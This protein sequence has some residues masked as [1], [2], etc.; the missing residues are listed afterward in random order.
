[1]S[2]HA[3]YEQSLWNALRPNRFPARF[4]TWLAVGMLASAL[5]HVG[6]FI[7]DGTP[8]TGSV[9]WRKPITFSVSFGLLM[10]TVGWI[11]DRLPDRRRLAAGVAIVLGLASS[12]EVALIVAQQWRGRASHFNTATDA[13]A[14][15]FTVMGIMVGLAALALLAVFVWSLVEP[16]ADG[17]DR[18]AVIAGMALVVTAL[19]FGQWVLSLGLDH[20]NR[21]GTV[22]QPVTA[23]DAGVAKFPHAVALHGI[24]LFIVGAA[25]LRRVAPS[26]RVGRRMMYTIV[27]AYS[28]MLAFAAMQTIS[29]RAPQDLRLISAVLLAVSLLVLAW[30]VLRIVTWWRRDSSDPV[31]ADPGLASTFSR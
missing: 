19:G 25:M 9:S 15:V 14:A 21:I 5:I 26:P 13:D 20:L 17:L 2:A 8:W 24:Q 4:L 10:W 7:M 28:G 22:P 31:A 27:G 29:G 6:V 16:P 18:I 23:G 3:A 11:L 30:A 12:V 1:M